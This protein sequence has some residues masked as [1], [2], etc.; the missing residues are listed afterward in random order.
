MHIN[1]HFDT[2]S[3]SLFRFVNQQNTPFLLLFFYAQNRGF[4]LLSRG[5]RQGIS[6]LSGPFRAIISMIFPFPFDES[7][8]PLKL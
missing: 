6:V 4:R 7:L 8:L 2:P 3:F 1:I 5:A